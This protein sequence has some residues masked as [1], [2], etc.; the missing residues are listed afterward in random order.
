MLDSV[1]LDLAR[2]REKFEKSRNPLWAWRAW[3][4]ARHHDHAVPDWVSSYLD[5]CAV[6]LL[7]GREPLPHEEPTG[8]IGRA[9]GFKHGLATSRRSFTRERTVIRA[10]RLINRMWDTAA[11][12]EAAAVELAVE[13]NCDRSTYLDALAQEADDSTIRGLMLGRL[14]ILDGHTGHVPATWAPWSYNATELRRAYSAACSKR[15]TKPPRRAGAAHSRKS[16]PPP[17]PRR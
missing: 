9:L 2:M 7:D 8:S 4:Y 10:I 14:A 1:D 16:H 17:I 12:A 11:S 15:R 6:A 3:D 5:Q 13:N